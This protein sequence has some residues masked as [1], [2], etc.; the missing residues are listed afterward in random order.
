MKSAKATEP[1]LKIREVL[2]EVGPVELSKARRSMEATPPQISNANESN[3]VCRLRQQSQDRLEEDCKE[4]GRRIKRKDILLAW[5]G[6]T[7]HA[8]A[9]WRRP[10]WCRW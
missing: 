6:K 2:H 1:R 5:E 8:P 10:L 4:P 7:S 9:A 3:D